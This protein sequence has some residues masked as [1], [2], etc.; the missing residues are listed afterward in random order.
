M[1]FRKKGIK[2]REV[3]YNGPVKNKIYET[4]RDL[5]IKQRVELCNDDIDLANELKNI[6]IDYS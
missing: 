4:M 2:F 3:S 1:K 6:T 5:F